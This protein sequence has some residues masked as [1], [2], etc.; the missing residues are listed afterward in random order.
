MNADLIQT[1]PRVHRFRR[2]MTAA[3]LASAVVA[4]GHVQAGAQ[5]EAPSSGSD[6]VLVW[7]ANAVAAAEAACISPSDDPLHESRMYAMM[8]VAIHDALNAI[9]RRFRPYVFDDREAGASPDAAVASAARNVLVPVLQELPAP[10]P[11]SCIDAGVA[12]VEAAYSAA[13]A[14]IPGGGGKSDGVELGKKAAA[15]VVGLRAGDGSDTPLIVDTYP[16]GTQPGEYRFTPGTPIRVRPGVG[17]GDPVRVEG[18]ST[19]PSRSSRRGD[20]QAVHGGLQG[21]Q[22][23]RW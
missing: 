1:H 7:S 23:P 9:D 10:F 12:S 5:P 19:V 11:Q 20:Q 2:A 18:R 15:A 22:A 21:G 3:C 17:D 13:L 4:A 6:A 8:H 16:Q 14:A